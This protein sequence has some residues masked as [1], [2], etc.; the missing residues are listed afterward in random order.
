MSLGDKQKVVRLFREFGNRWKLI[1]GY[2]ESRTDNFIK[3]QFFG[4]VRLGFRKIIRLFGIKN[5]SLILNTVKPKTLLEFVRFRFTDYE[6]EH[7]RILDVLEKFAFSEKEANEIFSEGYLRAAKDI[8]ITLFKFVK[9]FYHLENDTLDCFLFDPEKKLEDVFRN[10]GI[11]KFQKQRI[12]KKICKRKD[13][14]KENKLTANLKDGCF[15][16][17]VEKKAN[18][19][20]PSYSNRSK[21]LNSNKSC[22]IATKK[23]K[24]LDFLKHSRATK[25]FMLNEN[26]ADI[27]FNIYKS[28]EDVK[29]Y[30]METKDVGLN[31]N[32]TGE[33]SCFLNRF[34]E[35]AEEER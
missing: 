26:F 25:E 32:E 21:S 12:K 19:S 35:K 28:F 11:E 4:I 30:I 20:S 1:S 18:N 8:L 33:V 17:Y 13:R 3:N 22:Q 27:V 16:E 23:F 5:R 7:I 29:N 14:V 15:K 24:Y 2:F 6:G 9:Q 34:V 31:Q 10:F